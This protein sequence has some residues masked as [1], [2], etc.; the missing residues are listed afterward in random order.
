MALNVPSLYFGWYLTM[1]WVD[2][3]QHFLGGLLV[4][5]FMAGYFRDHFLPKSNLN[6]ALLVIGASIFVG[7]FWEFAEYIANQ[8][9]IEP[10]QKWFGIKAYF[11]GDLNDTVVDLMMDTM[12]AITTC[13]FILRKRST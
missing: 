6:N 8:T 5:M 2:T 10:F 13:L 11:M 4:A 9:L 12:G 7:V 1:G 3:V